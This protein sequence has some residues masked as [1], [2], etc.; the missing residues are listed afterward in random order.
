MP[1]LRQ[2]DASQV[3]DE[4]Q[5]L[6]NAAELFLQGV[7]TQGHESAKTHARCLYVL[8]GDSPASI[9]AKSGNSLTTTYLCELSHDI[10]WRF[11]VCGA[12][13]SSECEPLTADQIK[14]LRR[15][16]ELI[17]NSESVLLMAELD[18]SDPW[19]GWKTSKEY[20]VDLDIHSK[21]IQRAL[22]ELIEKKKADRKSERGKINLRQ[23]ACEILKPQI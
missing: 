17:R 3:C 13:L 18:A 14:I 21:K 23:S 15:W 11:I 19:Q 9:V 10:P 8:L 7:F 4:L 6:C 5:A 1:K 16:L 12:D 22:P 20:A 2:V